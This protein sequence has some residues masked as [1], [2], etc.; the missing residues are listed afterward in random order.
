MTFDKTE[1]LLV[2]SALMIV[3]AIE[4]IKLAIFEFSK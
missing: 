4:L 3:M 2:R 1:R